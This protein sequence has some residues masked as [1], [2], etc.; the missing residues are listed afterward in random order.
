M[1]R[2][3]EKYSDFGFSLE[4]HQRFRFDVEQWPVPKAVVHNDELVFSVSSKKV[5]LPPSLLQEFTDLAEADSTLIC[6]FANRWG[7]LGLCEH[8]L[9]STHLL[10][11]V[12]RD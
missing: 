7:R 11:G 6:L 2:K 9:P 1:R 12:I 10:P 4:D 8:G 3:A 5:A